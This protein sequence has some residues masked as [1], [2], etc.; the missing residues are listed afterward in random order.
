MRKFIIKRLAISVVILFFVALIVYTIMRCM[1]ASFV[2]KMAREKASLPGGKSYR[3]W[4]EQLE[5]AYGLN[6]SIPAGFIHWLGQ[7]IRGNFG[8]SWAFNVPVTEK[9]SEVIWD[10]FTLGAI[11]FIFEILI[12]VPLGILAARK[13]YSR[14]DYAVTV[15]G[16][17][18][19]SLPSFF[20][21]TLLKYVFSIKLGWFDLFGMIG[22]MYEHLSPFGKF[23]DR[24]NHLV[25]P[26]VT[27]TIVNI[28]ALMRYTR[29][30]MLEVLNSDYIRTARAKGLS[31]R[32]V[33]NYH[34]FRNTLI[35][36]V[37]IIGGTLPGLFSG[38]M[39]TETLFQIEGIGYTA[40]QAM[41]TG[42]IPFSMFYLVFLAMLTLL[43]NLIADILYAVVDPRVRIN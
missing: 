21:A 39:I 42:D 35:P 15:F 5:A 20:F 36:I 33:I 31:E 34:A 13:Q 8:D 28:G 18:G 25:L 24:A 14:T 10:S 41:T 23:L 3:E 11:S 37:T 40:Y 19:I 1:P 2:E 38:A 32:R 6:K 43:G 29:T 4:L 12:A 26:I 30:N 17:I 27:L 9:F 7:A 16:L 22:R